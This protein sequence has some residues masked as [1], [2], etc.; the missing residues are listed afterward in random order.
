MQVVPRAPHRPDGDHAPSVL[1]D[2]RQLNPGD[3]ALRRDPRL[4]PAHRGLGRVLLL[5]HVLPHLLH[6][7]SLLHQPGNHPRVRCVLCAVACA[8]V[9]VCARRS[10]FCMLRIKQIHKWAHSH[11]PPSA[12]RALQKVGVI[13][14]G[15]YTISLARLARHAQHSTTRTAH[16]LVSFLLL[17]LT[18]AGVGW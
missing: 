9:L 4:Q 11:E 17:C 8:V 1:R 5:P 12:V 6:P 7:P 10:S 3:A 13:L 14:E 15:R 16:Y 2:Q 18:R